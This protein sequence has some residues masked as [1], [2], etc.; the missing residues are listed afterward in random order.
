MFGIGDCGVFG[1]S[2]LEGQRWSN[3]SDRIGAENARYCDLGI[4]KV[5][6]VSSSVDVTSSLPSCAFAIS[7]AM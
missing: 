5:K 4:D 2:T 1:L 7:E 3:V 6:R